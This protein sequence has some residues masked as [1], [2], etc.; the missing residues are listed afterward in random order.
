MRFII[1]SKTDHIHRFIFKSQG[2]AARGRR[3]LDRCWQIRGGGRLTFIQEIYQFCPF[4]CVVAEFVSRFQA[5]IG[6]GFKRFDLLLK[7]EIL[8]HSSGCF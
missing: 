5:L 7:I 4:R 1:F 6:P 2:H 8:A 3:L